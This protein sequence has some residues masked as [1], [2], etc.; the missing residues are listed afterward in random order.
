MKQLQ[1]N[2]K[3]KKKIYR[4]FLND[5]SVRSDIKR[6]FQGKKEK[7]LVSGGLFIYPN[8][9]TP[10]VRSDYYST[11]DQILSKKLHELQAENDELKQSKSESTEP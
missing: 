6:D 5:V 2:Q 11:I 3:K 10:E 7:I 4:G 9:D 8:I 1:K